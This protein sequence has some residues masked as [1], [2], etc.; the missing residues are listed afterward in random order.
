MPSI[1]RYYTP[2]RRILC[3][4]AKSRSTIQYG[5]LA[6]ALGLKSARQ[7]W[8]TLLDP[9]ARKESERTGRDLTLVVVYA[10][11]PAKGLGRY[12]SNVRGGTPPGTT[13]LDPADLTQVANFYAE[14]ENVFDAYA[15][16]EC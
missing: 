14:L 11:G 6:T 15:D 16:V 5:E 8:H 2:A 13:T 4:I 3:E 9:I 7:E 1:L 10:T 12:F